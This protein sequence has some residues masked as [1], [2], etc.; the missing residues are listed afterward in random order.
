MLSGSHQRLSTAR[1]LCG[2][3]ILLPALASAE[4]DEGVIIECIRPCT[5][6]IAAVRGLGG[7]VTEQYRNVDAVAARVPKSAVSQLAAALGGEQVTKDQIVSSPVPRSVMEMSGD[8]LPVQNYALTGQALTH[9]LT[10]HPNNY[11]FTGGLTGAA[12][13]HAQGKI[14]QGIIVAVIDTGTANNANVVPALA[15]TVIGGENFV[16]GSSEPGATS[17]LN[18]PHGT[19]VGS[20]I[21]AHAFFAFNSASGLVQSVSTHSPESVIP[22]PDPAFPG[23]PAG[24]SIIPMI[25][26]APGANIYALKVFPATGDGAPASRIIAAMDHAITLRRNFNN[27]VPSVPSGTGT[28]NDPFVFTSL[29]VDVVNMSLGGPTLFA[30]RDLEDRLTREMLGVGITIVTSAGN[31]GLGAMTGGSPGTGF[32]SLTT[33]AASTPIHERIAADLFFVGL[34]NGVLWRPSDHIQTANF[35]SRGPTADGRHDP[36]MVANGDWCFVQGANGGLSLASGTS[37]SSPT[38]AGAAALLRGES[39]NSMTATQV[40]NALVETAN[41]NLLGDKSRINDQGKG[42]LNVPAALDRLESGRAS[43]LLPDVFHFPTPVVALNVLL[44]GDKIVTF[45]NDSFTTRVR[46]LVPGQV[47]QFFVPSDKT[48]DALTVTLSNITPELPPAEQNFF[49]GDDVFLNIVDSPTSFGEFREVAFVNQDSSFDVP[50]PQTGLVRVALQGDWT[51]AGRVSADLTITRQRSP[52]GKATALGRVHEGE[53]VPV[54]VNIPAGTAQAVIELH[55][56]GNWGRYPTNDL[57]MVVIGP[58]GAP[59][60][61]DGATIASPERVELINPAPGIWTIVVDGFTIHDPF[62]HTPDDDWILR[63][64]ADGVRLKQVP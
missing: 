38:V 19:W 3:L 15:G 26:T 52:F 18:D 4:S 53:Q 56:E 5:A 17:T 61:L 14:G 35:S 16:P 33:G 59:V 50:L 1:M 24:L 55:W 63:V 34:G 46:N 42:F 45:K 30:G 7:R 44:Q 48:T 12:S 51:N 22:C 23:C 60:E 47:A 20:M 28:E 27:G 39:P 49:F 57:D 43:K 9:A 13:L 6:A 29:K 31:D 11:L 37:F 2:L 10:A 21:A 58:G 40:R 32:G 36:Q 25:G 64:T 54:E 41:K 8:Q 62:D